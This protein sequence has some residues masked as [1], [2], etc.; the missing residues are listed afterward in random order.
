MREGMPAI[1]RLQWISGA[2][3][4]IFAV[5]PSVARLSDHCRC[6]VLTAMCLHALACLDGHAMRIAGTLVHM[7]CRTKRKPLEELWYVERGWLK[8]LWAVPQCWPEFPTWLCVAASSNN[9]TGGGL[10]QGSLACKSSRRLCS[11]S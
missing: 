11:R 7:P 9:T 4:T 10:S 8:V 1:R 6:W 2:P 5:R 3:T